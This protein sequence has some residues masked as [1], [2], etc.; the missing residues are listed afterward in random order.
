MVLNKQNSWNL[1]SRP[2]L[3]VIIF[4]R[5]L[6]VKL[7]RRANAAIYFKTKSR[8]SVSTVMFCHA[9]FISNSANKE[10]QCLAIGDYYENCQSRLNVFGNV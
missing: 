9:P 2:L 10:N 1:V 8:F 5:N 3:E 7:G 4:S 6:L